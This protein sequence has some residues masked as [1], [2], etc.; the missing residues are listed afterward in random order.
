M[1][2]LSG[3]LDVACP[4]HFHVVGVQQLKG[5]FKTIMSGMLLLQEASQPAEFAGSRYSMNI[6]KAQQPKAV[7]CFSK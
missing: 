6:F 2:V 4:G 3:I 7:A 5:Q 1:I